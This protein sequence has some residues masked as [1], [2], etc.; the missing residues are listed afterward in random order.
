MCM[1][2]LIYYIKKE[3]RKKNMEDEKRANLIAGLAEKIMTLISVEALPGDIN[4]SA[5]L[6]VLAEI[7]KNLPIGF[8]I[9]RLTLHEFI[10]MAI[11]NKNITWMQYFIRNQ[12]PNN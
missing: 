2:N 12:Y 9:D 1:R 3:M 6:T 10:E 5:I 7:Y 8:N 4:L 11:N